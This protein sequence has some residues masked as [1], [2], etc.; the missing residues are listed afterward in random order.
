MLW[1]D[2]LA[3]F[4]EEYDNFVSKFYKET[5]L[6]SKVYEKRQQKKKQYILAGNNSN[7]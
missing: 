1:E 6:D 4:L 3:C 5:G 2:D 7:A